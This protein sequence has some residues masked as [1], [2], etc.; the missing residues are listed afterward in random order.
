MLNFDFY[1]TYKS[2][3]RNII[4]LKI[5]I[6]KVKN[7]FYLP[8]LIKL[9][10][11]FL[12]IKKQDK[13]NISI[14]NYF[15][16]FKFFFGKKAFLSKYKTFYNLG[17]W[18]YSFKVFIFINKNEVYP[19]LLYFFNDFLN[20][21]EKNFF[22]FGI[23]NKNFNIFYLVLKDLTIFNEKKTNLGL[24]NLEDFFNIYLYFSGCDINNSLIILKNLK[25]KKLW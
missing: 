10:I 22:N 8:A 25:L 13:D 24:F 9:K 2:C 12:L 7:T 6:N 20:L 5:G 1:F 21:I 15:Y 4:L 11:F 18:Y 3:L 19:I 17:I 23:L 16:L 14:S